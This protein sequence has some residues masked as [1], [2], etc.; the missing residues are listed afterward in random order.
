[1]LLRART[2]FMGEKDQNIA[3][4]H[5]NKCLMGGKKNR[6]HVL[7]HALWAG[8]KLKTHFQNFA[9]FAPKE[10]IKIKLKIQWN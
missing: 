4:I 7:V 9:A 3:L 1:M 6:F 2:C 10:R 5:A 8:K